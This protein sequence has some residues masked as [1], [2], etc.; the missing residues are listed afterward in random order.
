MKRYWTIITC[1]GIVAVVLAS[2][3]ACFAAAMPDVTIL[4]TISD[5]LRTPGK[6]ALDRS[7]MIYVADTKNRG[8]LKLDAFGRLKARIEVTGV[9][10]SV[11]C[12]ADG[13]VI[14]SHGSTVTVYNSAGVDLYNLSGFVFDLPNGITTDAAGN[15]YVA[16]SK[17]NKIVV[18]SQTGQYTGSFG[19]PGTR[20][21]QLNFPTGIAY[22][23][24]TNQIAVADT[25]NN[26]VQF[27]DTAGNIKRTIGT[28]TI[29]S[30]PLCFTYP[31]G[32]A[33]DY[34][35]GVR[36]FVVD[37][38]QSWVQVIDVGQTAPAFL[39][40]I[41]NY[42]F[43]DG[44][45]T[46]PSDAVID[47]HNGRLLVVDNSGLITLFGIDGG[48]N[49]V[50]KGFPAAL[51]DPVPAIVT[52]ADLFIS[53]SVEAGSTVMVELGNAASVPGSVKGTSWGAT[54]KLSPGSNILAVTA[55][56][57]AGK[58]TTVSVAVMYSSAPPGDD[59][60]I[61]SDHSSGSGDTT[62]PGSGHRTNA[63]AVW[64][65]PAGT[66]CRHS[67]YGTVVCRDK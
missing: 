4:G 32:I 16:D 43:A 48:R 46:I 40:Y 65:S 62:T 24:I 38:Y 29:L 28:P 13:K 57:P 64:V 19:V 54:V 7:G 42:G 56:S 20:A 36:M 37:T 31:Q 6:I 22:E 12:T 34:A 18:F 49:P 15:I 27:F 53:G 35:V 59:G 23:K 44:Q 60:S 17:A 50:D 33:F 67:R 3:E 55:T 10:R 26:R 45:F 51:L 1:L 41:G 11:A 14:A 2:L 39:G 5:N 58:T 52:A 25:L 21:G 9:V 30:G 47:S 63:G 8:I 66:D 61:S